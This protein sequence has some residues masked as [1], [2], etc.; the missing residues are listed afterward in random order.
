[1]LPLPV[2]AIAIVVAVV[3]SIAWSGFVLAIE[4]E[5]VAGMSLREAVD[6]RFA[7]GVGV[8]HAILNNPE[9][10]AL[11]KKHFQI[12]TP[13]NC[14]K[15]QGI[16]PREGEFRFA[17]TDRFMAFA[18]ENQLEAVGHCLV[19]AKDDRTSEWMMKD[20]DQAVGAEKLLQ[21][22]GD[23]IET[24]MDRYADTVTMWDVV[25]EALADSDGEYLR[26]SVYTRTTGDKFLV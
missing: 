11:I 2:R 17:D 18:R 21:R 14:M 1:M 22:I 23:H 26:D 19:W 9:D 13:E 12:I 5:D 24:V 6:G 20:G 10:A 16:Q 15:P 4:P 8:S 25:N 7:I 3:H